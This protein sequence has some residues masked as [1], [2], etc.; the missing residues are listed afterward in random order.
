[1][2]QTTAGSSTSNLCEKCQS[3]D[4]EQLFLHGGH[5]TRINF[6][7]V[8]NIVKRQDCPFCDL[9]TE[10]LLLSWANVP[11]DWTLRYEPDDERGWSMCRLT[12][13]WGVVK[14]DVFD[15]DCCIITLD[16][17]DGN[18]QK[19]EPEYYEPEIRLVR[20]EREGPRLG[21]ARVLDDVCDF[22]LIQSW[23]TQCEASHPVPDPLPPN[24]KHLRVID[25]KEMRVIEAP[26]YCSYAALS[27]VWG[28]D[29]VI[30]KSTVAD[31][32]ENKDSLKMDN[33]PFTIQD[34]ITLLRKLGKGYLWVDSL[35]I[36]QDGPHK[37]EQI[38]LMVDIYRNA[39]FT[40]V[41]AGSGSATAHLA[42]VTPSSRARKTQ[43][44]ASVKGF[45]LALSTPPLKFFLD[46]CAWSK[47][48]WTYQEWQFSSR[49][50]IF[51]PVEVFF[52]CSC[53]TKCESIVGEQQGAPNKLRPVK[54]LG[55]LGDLVDKFEIEIPRHRMV[56]GRG[57]HHASDWLGFVENYT[58]RQM[59][60]ESDVLLAL[61]STMDEFRRTVGIGVLAGLLETDLHVALMWQPS[62]PMRK[63]NATTRDG[64]LFPTWSW[65]G[66]VGPVHYELGDGTTEI[67]T[68][69]RQN[70]FLVGHDN[71]LRFLHTGKAADDG[72]QAAPSSSAA[73]EDDIQ[74]LDAAFG[75]RL[76]ME[77]YDGRSKERGDKFHQDEVRYNQMQNWIA[78]SQFEEL[79]GRKPRSKG[80]VALAREF[81][82]Y[83][84]LD[85]D[86]ATEH[87]KYLNGVYSG[88]HTPVFLI[89]MMQEVCEKKISMLRAQIAGCKTSNTDIQIDKPVVAESGYLVFKTQCAYFKV[90]ISSDDA[91]NTPLRS[92][93]IFNSRGIRVGNV[94]PNNNDHPPPLHA[95]FVVLCKQHPHPR[96]VITSEAAGQ[97]QF[98]DA[99]PL[100]KEMKYAVLMIER[101]NGTA[102]RIGQGTIAVP[103]WDR[104]DP[105]EKLIVLG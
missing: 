97:S 103:M 85:D 43:F 8:R 55:S 52:M 16:I 29:A 78:I 94:L 36:I 71:T 87:V 47:R 26:P 1:M 105:V 56:S 64:R 35:C 93:G 49:A 37:S 83:A 50:L 104:E 66:W 76:S 89:R 45:D 102:Y 11:L 14:D 19:F 69:L 10:A 4:F 72:N 48:A 88:E 86:L 12:G 65:C 40:I 70:W 30:L 63:R 75:V 98:G 5:F 67:T 9:I 73:V 80:E 51:T 22:K 33:L 38:E 74:K 90:R 25:I 34:T 46:A 62:G 18:E 60:Y 3:T 39:A 13:Q 54:G 84:G 28:T 15:H 32:F 91:A 92:Y 58:K 24:V 31:P 53:G 57:M 41:A 17:T 44:T 95:E 21:S 27:Y 101:R 81:L 79:T 2:D 59:T 82:A 77:E 23:I 20:K 6:D 99:W 42:A 96:L 61:W 100:M 7:Y 68:R